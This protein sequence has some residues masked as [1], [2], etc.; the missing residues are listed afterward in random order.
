[1]LAPPKAVRFLLIV[2]LENAVRCN[3]SLVCTSHHLIFGGMHSGKLSGPPGLR[4]RDAMNGTEELHAR[5]ET[6]DPLRGLSV[7]SELSDLGA[8]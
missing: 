4:E 2:S 8:Q 5:P 3:I 6:I 1:M 7:T